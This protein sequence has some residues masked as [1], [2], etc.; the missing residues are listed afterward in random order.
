[1]IKNDFDKKTPQI[2]GARGPVTTPTWN[3]IPQ[4]KQQQIEVIVKKIKIAE[5]ECILQSG[6]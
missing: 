1:M 4:H 5:L 6:K 3:A 2:H